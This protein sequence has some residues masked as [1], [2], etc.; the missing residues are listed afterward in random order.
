M[1]GPPAASD[2]A[3]VIAQSLEQ[4]EIFAL[5]YDRH[6]PEI[7][8]YIARRL[9]EG[10][11]E[12]ILAETFLIAFRRRGRYDP[13]RASARPWLYG[14]A[15]KLIG[16][17]RRSEVRALRA[18]ARSGGAP[19]DLVG[20]SWSERSD[21]RIAAQAPLAGALG[22]LSPGDR[23]VLLLVAWADLSYQEVSEALR[24]PLGTVRSRLNRARRKV[25]TALMADP[26]FAGTESDRAEDD[27]AGAVATAGPGLGAARGAAAH[28]V[29]QVAPL[30][31]FRATTQEP[32]GSALAAG[33]SFT[34]TVRS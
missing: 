4:P 18:V 9:G 22:A 31:V 1:T 28:P 30:G 14:I 7:Y 29:R 25:R 16:G 26:A 21:E 32:T 15:A 6:A 5:L 10:V 27:S 3:A 13:A 33:P 8:R 19:R 12:D 24:I 20:E 23:H 11:A 34:P 17:H 2:D